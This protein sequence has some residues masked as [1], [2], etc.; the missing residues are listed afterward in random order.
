MPT[1]QATAG[2]AVELIVLAIIGGFAV[3]TLIFWPMLRRARLGSRRARNSRARAGPT[4]K[5]ALRGKSAS[6]PA[7]TT[8]TD[9][10]AAATTA[11]TGSKPTSAD[12]TVES[13]TTSRN[14]RVDQPST[15]PIPALPTNLFAEHYAAKFDRT[16]KRI[17]RLRTQLNGQ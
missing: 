13:T 6:A 7:S 10:T 2:P 17:A 3:A 11:D 12:D 5:H 14:S 15:Q 4:G 8:A 1:V 16:R 9:T